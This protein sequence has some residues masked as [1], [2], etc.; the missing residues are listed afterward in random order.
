MKTTVSF[1]AIDDLPV[2]LSAEAKSGD[3]HVCMKVLNP[4]VRILEQLF[5]SWYSGRP[6]PFLAALPELEAL[7]ITA[8]ELL[9]KRFEGADFILEG[10][11]VTAP[12][13]YGVGL[14]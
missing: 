7:G 2:Q 1:G 9:E 3:I 11:V 13:K 8:L 14:A 4:S 12:A 5:K 6:V 10:R